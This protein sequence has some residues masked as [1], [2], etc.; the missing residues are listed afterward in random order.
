LLISPSTVKK[1]RKDQN[2]QPDLP[3]NIAKIIV[4]VEGDVIDKYAPTLE[5]I[6][7]ASERWENLQPFFGIVAAMFSAICSL[8]SMGHGP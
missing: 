5:T 1:K 4:D 3:S 8:R 6:Q 7:Q 2:K